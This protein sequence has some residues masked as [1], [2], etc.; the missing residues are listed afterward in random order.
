MLG[1]AIKNGANRGR[2]PKSSDKSSEETP[3]NQVPAPLSFYLPLSLLISMKP[4]ST[5]RL[6]DDTTQSVIGVGTFTAST[7]AKQL[8]M[9]ALNNNRLSYGPMMQQF[10]LE[11]ARLHGS[12]FG[13]MSNSGTSALQLALQAMKELHGWADGDE[14]IVPAVTFVATVNIV[15][16]NRMTP[17]LV[18]VDHQYYEINPE[19]IERAITPRTRAIIPVHLFGQPADMPRIVEIAR[20]HS[21]KIIEDSAETMF[22][23]CNG[24]RVGSLGDIG[25]FSTY[26][27]HLLVTGVGGMNTT[28]EPDYA[29][30]IRS[31]L[32]HG[33]DSIYI[34]ID[35]D[36]GKSKEELRTIVERRF[37]FTSIGHSFR[38]TEMEA[39]LG[40][41]QL[42]EWQPMVHR[43]RQNAAFLTKALERFDNHIQPPSIRSGCEHSFMMYPLVLHNEDKRRLVNFLE[44]SGIET[45]DMLP[46][47]NQ[48]VYRRLFGWR[49]DDFPVAQWINNNGFYIGCH[50]DLSDIDLEYI[51]ESFERYF[52]GLQSRI[53][54]DVG[55]ILLANHHTDPGA[56][57]LETFSAGL[58]KQALVI[59]AGMRRDVR[60]DL[61][62]KAFEIIDA[63][64]KDELAVAAELGDARGFGS[65]VLFPLN[66][67]WN[68]K[69][70]PRLMMGV[71]RG[72][73]L[74]IASRFI[75]GG[76]RRGR[77]GR[78]RS[79]GNR[80]FNLLA[81]LLFEGNLSDA[82]S[83]FRAV[84]QSKLA[85]L[86]LRGHGPV[87]FF[88]LSLEALKRD[89]RIQEIP[90]VEV[91]RSSRQ[92]IGDA[93]SNIVPA[94]IVLTKEW[95]RGRPTG[96]D[97]SR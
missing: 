15:L 25:C 14:V 55:L 3:S 2:A 57:D 84:R 22:A 73:D 62:R 11:F 51:V 48:P 91:T 43:R 86:S 45:R 63:S 1:A 42:E 77:H 56:V 64:G 75:M 37:R 20:A 76:A 49:E 18:D 88:S 66:G 87:K 47:T 24:L 44:E 60:A 81:N 68:P 95:W 69:D 12:R 39:A 8:V 4:K 71:S 65:V 89:W 30:K 35:D 31:L 26:V 70:I 54:D 61:E 29:V 9:E 13:I 80:V 59:D 78:L 32:N 34:S 93:I 19:L 23:G 58:F 74:V 7:R 5:N 53:S 97:G 96:G 67:Q 72:Y 28:N 83:S 36:D 50:H 40:L 38:A 33:R 94:L 21:L 41:S 52:G 79:L 82:F 27:A 10:E 16:H 6:A 46:L 92:V 17:V 85:E 90:T